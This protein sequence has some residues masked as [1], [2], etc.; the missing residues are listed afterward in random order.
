M[1]GD[2]G[3]DPRVLLK[4]MSNSGDAT[5]INEYTLINAF[6]VH[7]KRQNLDLALKNIPNITIF[8][9]PVV[10]GIG[11]D[12]PV[13]AWGVDRTDQVV[14]TN[15]QYQYERDGDN[16]DVYVL[17][18]GVY[19]E[20]NDFEGRAK[21]GADFTGEGNYDGRGHGSHVAGTLH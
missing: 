5:S 16:V 1:M 20:H 19:I 2:E 15:N 21:H 10:T 12:S 8:D 18:T 7:M 3:V 9:N 13:Y 6:S 14:G 11:F 17:D 4:S